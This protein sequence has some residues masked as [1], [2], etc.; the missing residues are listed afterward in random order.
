M[1]L[2][3]SIY[4]GFAAVVA[5][6]L[7]VVLIEWRRRRNRGDDELLSEMATHLWNLP[8]LTPPPEVAG[9]LDFQKEKVS[10]PEQRPSNAAVGM[11]ANH[12]ESAA[13][14]DSMS[15]RQGEARTPPEAAQSEARIPSTE[16]YEEDPDFALVKNRGR[17]QRPRVMDPHHLMWEV[18]GA[19]TGAPKVRPPELEAVERKIEE[20]LQPVRQSV[21]EKSNESIKKELDDPASNLVEQTRKRLEVEVHSALETFSR[22]VDTRL[23]TLAEAQVSQ[24]VAELQAEITKQTQ[25]QISD[26]REGCHPS[27]GSV[28]EAL[29]GRVKKQLE[30]A[31]SGLVE[32]TRRRLQGEVFSALETFGREADTR[33]R[34]LEREQVLQSV[35]KLRTE[36]TAQVQEQV[37]DIQNAAREVHQQVSLMADRITPLLD[38]RELILRSVRAGEQSPDPDA[39]MRKIDLAVETAASK[40]RTFEHQTEAHLAEVA[41]A[42]RKTSDDLIASS[43]SRLEGQAEATA[44]RLCGELRTLQTRLVNE[45]NKQLAA[46]IQAPLESMTSKAEAI[47]EQCRRQLR[48]ELDESVRKT[49]QELEAD[50]R[51]FLVEQR[52]SFQSAF[53][54][55]RVAANQVSLESLKREAQAI[56]E[57]CRARLRQAADAALLASVPKVEADHE[58][59]MRPMELYRASPPN[60]REESTQPQGVPTRLED[61][62]H[63][64]LRAA[65]WLLPIA[66]ILLFVMLSIRPVMYL[67]TDP[68][69]EFFEGTQDSNTTQRVTEEHLARAYWDSAIR[70]VQPKYEFGTNL[71]DQPLPEFKLEGTGVRDGSSKND[72]DARGRYWRRLRQVWTRPQAWEKSY[73]WDTGWIDAALASLQRAGRQ[74]VDATR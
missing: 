18:V 66:P 73:V 13:L 25:K 72:S 49:V 28:S 57:E 46:M 27:L 64:T 12:R 15:V 42:L 9:P 47:A 34:S 39:A 26:I 45:A 37:S 11:Q 1:S 38:N 21:R 19:E 55:Q 44:E 6:A 52:E 51:E 2:N 62:V 50:A 35:T 61:V 40:L 41:D 32:Q 67:R 53:D 24:G 69:A 63:A 36:I 33:L 68:P 43:A 16:R 22:E 74:L 5:V 31:A 60:F 4:I 23:R 3:V 14:P 10:S 56:I 48:Q 8:P 7:T 59:V 20:T 58:H 29:D 70:Y 65:I 71:P 30:V 17:Q 54:G